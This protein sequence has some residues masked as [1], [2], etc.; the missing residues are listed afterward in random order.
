MDLRRVQI[1]DAKLLFAWTNDPITRKNSFS[2][3]PI[4]WEN[5]VKWLEKKLVDENCL[6]LILEDKI[7]HGKVACGTIR[8]DL[9]F[10][11]EVLI[12][13]SI[14]PEQRGKGYGEAIVRLGE[15]EAKKAFGDITLVAEVKQENEASKKCFERNGYVLKE[16]NDR[17]AVY[18]K[19]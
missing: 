9:R 6:F 18:E 15:A 12:S 19:R 10:D 3:E 1:D 4:L 13:Y 8:Y 7:D 16:T 11:K 5:H 2:R 17:E 14:A